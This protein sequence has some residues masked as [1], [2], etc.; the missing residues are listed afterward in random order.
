MTSPVT[1][2][3][4]IRQHDADTIVADGTGSTTASTPFTY[5]FNFGDGNTSGPQ[6]SPTIVHKYA[7][8][9][10]YT[11]TLTVTGADTGTGTASQVVTTTLPLTSTAFANNEQSITRYSVDISGIPDGAIDKKGTILV[12]TGPNQLAALEPG[13]DGKVLTTD[14]TTAYG[15]KWA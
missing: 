9:G 10:T 4:A 1:A 3:L 14:S 8:A 5:S 2:V 11:V 7:V 13:V 12:V 6:A 15:V